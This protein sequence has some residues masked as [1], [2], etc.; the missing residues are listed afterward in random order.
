MQSEDFNLLR[1]ND[2][3]SIAMRAK[4]LQ[5]ELEIEVGQS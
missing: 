3:I 1:A 5:Q 2:F 4:E